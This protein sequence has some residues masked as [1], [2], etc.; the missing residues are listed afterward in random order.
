MEKARPFGPLLSRLILGVALALGALPAAAFPGEGGVSRAGA[1]EAPLAWEDS[2]Y[3]H[4]GPSQTLVPG[5][6]VLFD[7]ADDPA[8]R[9]AL[10]GRLR[11]LFVGLY[12][13]DAWR[14]PFAEGELLRIYVA[15]TPSGDVRRLTASS[16]SNGR[17]VRP[18]VLLDATGLNA[19]Q[20]IREVVRRVVLATL[21]AYGVPEDAFLTPAAA[22]VLTRAGEGAADDELWTLAAAPEL[23]LRARPA[24]LGR[25]WVDEALRY[26][27]NPGFLRQVWQRA[28]E[29]GDSPMPV[30][31]RM[32][33]ETASLG[34]ET[35][36][37]RAAARL[38]ATVEPD[39]GPSRLRLL[40]LESGAL[41]AAPPETFTVRHRTFLP[42]GSEDSLRVSWPED[43]G[44]GAATV[45]Y[46]DPALPPDV[47]FFQP[48]DAR[49]LPLSG[50]ARIDFVVAGAATRPGMLRAPASVER[51]VSRPYGGLAVQA[52]AGAD[53]PR[54]TWSTASHEGMRGWAIF[55]EEVL[56]DG[57]VVRVG[58]EIVPSSVESS[59]SFR[60]VFVDETA[61]RGTFYRYTAWAVTDD[62]LLARA[63][64]VTLRT[65]D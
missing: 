21:A 7:E 60:Y 63:F 28:A 44:S 4:F 30:F 12:E 61:V 51:V 6:A 35:L 57:R 22:E 17:L 2:P 65:Q 26:T 3:R 41:D 42:D 1:P 47:V 25:L 14:F 48:R 11:R 19:P 23:D 53:G 10:S 40:D 18:S 55:R 24:G 9:S 16:V 64:A 43:A 39:P 29:T 31:M 54:L 20:I 36:L 49:T 5:R 58:P 13:D 34:E 62:G 15:R 38:Y 59:D 56:A 45:R 46:R 33:A 52:L 8:L 37:V 27:G 50:V 32:I